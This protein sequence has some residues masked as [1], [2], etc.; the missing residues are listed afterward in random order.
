MLALAGDLGPSV[1]AN[2]L[3]AF[4]SSCQAAFGR[5]VCRKDVDSRPPPAMTIYANPRLFA[6]LAAVLVAKPWVAEPSPTMTPMGQNFGPLGHYSNISTVRA[7]SPAFMA[8]NA[9]F[10]PSSGARRLIMSSR[11]SRPWR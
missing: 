8:R 9:S 4:V 5:G 6:K 7:T 1:A 3:R 2:K 10:T 11:F